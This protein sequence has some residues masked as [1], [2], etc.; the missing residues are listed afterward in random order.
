MLVN[1]LQRHAEELVPIPWRSF[2]QQW[3]AT[4]NCS[5]HM[6][7]LD[8]VCSFKYQKTYY[9]MLS[10]M[11]NVLHFFLT[12]Y[13]CI[14]NILSPFYVNSNPS[15]MLLVLCC[16]WLPWVVIFTLPSLYWHVSSLKLP[17][18]ELKLF[19]VLVLVLCV[20]VCF[21]FFHHGTWSEF[22]TR[23]V[24]KIICPGNGNP[25]NSENMARTH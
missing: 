12:K 2:M 3:L 22:F 20:F 6:E 24:F 23:E 14:P 16:L 7:L 10:K 18:L 13:F 9:G 8:T 1:L 11:C 19:L 25:K 17:F 15:E 21:Y 4:F 5:I